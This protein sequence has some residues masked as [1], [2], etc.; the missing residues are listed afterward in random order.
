[1]AITIN[2]TGS[3]TGLTAGGLPDGS[4]TNADLEYAGTSGQVLTSQGSGS[5]P[6]WATVVAENTQSLTETHVSAP[7]TT[8]ATWT[9][10]PADIQWITCGWNEAS[11][12]TQ[13]S[14]NERL[15]VQVGTGATPT[16]K[17]SNYWNTSWNCTNG[18]SPI[19]GFD[20]LAKA[21][22]MPYFWINNTYRETIMISLQR[23]GTS[24]NW[25]FSLQG[26]ARS[27][28]LVWSSGFFD[29]GADITA[30]RI[31]TVNGSATLNNGNFWIN[32][33]AR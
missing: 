15:I 6:Q 16:W 27:H 8:A 3:I 2:G 33:G 9:D 28:Y 32:Y 14:E 13:N 25:A 31:T 1:M 18:S 26:V 11:S 7:N 12:S 30:L 20:N 17:T 10:L 23:L 24:N 19:I 29:V 21:G 4:V 5:A 22:V